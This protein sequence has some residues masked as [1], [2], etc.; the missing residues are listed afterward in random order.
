MRSL[1]AT[2]T[3][4]PF[5]INMS[6]DIILRDH[7]NDAW[8]HFT[9]PRRVLVARSLDE[10]TATLQEAEREVNDNGRWAA[11][12]LAYEAAAAF[13]AVL[14]THAPAKVPLVWFGIYDGPESGPPPHATRRKYAAGW[15]PTMERG[16]YMDGLDT[17]KRHLADG[18]TY[19]VNFTYRLHSIFDGDPREYF[20]MLSK[21]AA[22]HYC[23]FVDTGRF[24][25]CS[26]S[27]EL[28]FRLDGREL[29]S[30]PMKGTAPRALTSSADR[31][32]AARLRY[33]EK[34]LAEN[35][36]IVDMI[37]NDMGRVAETGTVTAPVLFHIERY[38][39]VWQM[40]STVT[41]E[42]DASVAEIMTAMFPCASVTGAP[43]R[44]TMR[45][46]RELE[47]TPRGVYTGTIGYIAPGRRAQFNV[48][49]RTVVVDTEEGTAEYGVGGGIVWDSTNEGEYQETLAKAAVLT[50][51]WPEFSLL[52]TMAWRPGEGYLLLRYH[53][54]RL[55]RSADY[56]GIR[57]EERAVREALAVV[58]RNFGAVAMRVRMLV[59]RDGTV[60]CES[61]RLPR[62]DGPAR[63]AIADTPVDSSDLY[64]YHKTTHREVYEKARAGHPDAD[65]VILYNER[66]E[67]TESCIANV[68]V[69]I[70][71]QRYT[72]PVP[73]GLLAGT[74][75]Q[76][77]LDEHRVEERI[78]SREDLE[79]ADRVWLVN[80]VRG[81]REATLIPS[82]TTQ[83]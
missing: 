64:L 29:T 1:D 75:R 69:E 34:E 31:A 77:M 20:G 38:P 46:I 8:L 45:I 55:L 12:Y 16:A 81:E 19:Q 79:R 15:K 6:G 70:D 5:E 37:R 22:A 67:I 52:E 7:T 56:F 10:V 25:I 4:I 61:S 49:I 28:F 33:S 42:T 9:E 58:D 78:I 27:P 83:R 80:S 3:L 17:I 36:M 54:D 50:R 44:R 72:P 35:V 59:A 66:D 32:E 60:T 51:R 24:A 18:D 74:Y 68:V 82:V 62:V 26:V 14:E 30:Q 39:T 71:G 41:C 57:V 47:T 11:G 65:D 63:V 21:D 13:D 73:C 2:L 76:W 43:R 53:L 40:T 23:A 48:A